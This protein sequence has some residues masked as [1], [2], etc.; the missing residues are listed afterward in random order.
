M[1]LIDHDDLRM[2]LRI[3]LATMGKPARRHVGMDAHFEKEIVDRMMSVIDRCVIVAPS[4]VGFGSGLRHGTF[5]V[6]EP[7]PFP[8]LVKD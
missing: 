3:K 1:R 8:E 4:M 7:H 6:D 2:E 5:G